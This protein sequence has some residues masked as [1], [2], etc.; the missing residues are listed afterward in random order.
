MSSLCRERKN[1]SSDYLG[2]ESFAVGIG[3]C[4]EKISSVLQAVAKAFAGH[5]FMAF[6]AE[7]PLCSMY[8]ENML[9]GLL[10]CAPDMLAIEA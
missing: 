5:A 8:C 10:E 1:H 3:G 9:E 7:A 6:D 2:A 4:L